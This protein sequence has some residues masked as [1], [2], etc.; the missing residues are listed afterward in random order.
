MAVLWEAMTL[1]VRKR[2]DEWTAKVLVNGDPN[3]SRS[4]LARTVP[5]KRR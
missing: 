4:D 1:S 3:P 5:A 2:S